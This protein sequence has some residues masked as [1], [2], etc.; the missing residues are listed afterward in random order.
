MKILI[1]PTIR[2]IYK[3]QFEFCTDLKLLNFLKKVFR[4][5]TL[6]TYNLTKK[7]DYDL[8]V[9]A[10]GNNSI[11]KSK[12]D[13][14]RD[15]INNSFFSYSIE[16]NKAILGIC[17]GAHYLAKKNGFKIKKKN[18]HVGSHKVIFNINKIKFSKVV[19]SFHNETIEYKKINNVNIFGLSEDGT[20]ESFHIKHKKILG[21]MWHP[22]RYNKFKYFDLKLLREFY[23]T[24]NIIGG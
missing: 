22:E 15:K 13:K 11:I 8:L 4:N 12:A 17:H 2:E 10:G 19:N 7:N 20:I 16:K 3:N 24:N 6:E 23:A 21:I 1:I 9:L 18:N 14:L 5:S